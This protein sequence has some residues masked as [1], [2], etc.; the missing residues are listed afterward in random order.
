MNFKTSYIAAG[1]YPVKLIA[2]YLG[3]GEAV[4]RLTPI[5]TT[6]NFT[7]LC[8]LKCPY[9]A[10]KERRK[11]DPHMTFKTLD[12]TIT[13][14]RS[15]GLQAVSISGGG[16]GTLHPDF[17][18]F[19]E[20]L[21][22]GGLSVALVTNGTMLKKISPTVLKS[23]AW[24]RVSMDGHR[25]EIPEIPSCI[26]PGVSWVYRA[27][28]R[29][30]PLM[31]RLADMAGA[32]EIKHLRIQQDIY[33]AATIELPTDLGN[34]EGVLLHDRKEYWCGSKKCW[35]GHVWPRVDVDGRM[36]PCCGVHYALD[37]LTQSRNYP[38]VL[39]MG[40]IE[41]Y[42]EYIDEQKP[43][44]GSPCKMCFYRPRIDFLEALTKIPRLENPEFA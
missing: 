7:N 9:C 25:G 17:E 34:R 38:E 36:W 29:E 2:H 16:E 15:L 21:L 18:E 35:N 43:F 24:I 13:T 3:K 28:D 27:V 14:L 19:I 12:K 39:C 26:N 11:D 4:P 6:I 8:N 30:N 10:T 5:H 33:N 1:Q 42:V 22:S 44:D 32:G 41:D 37:K 23:L 20:Y 40:S 31:L